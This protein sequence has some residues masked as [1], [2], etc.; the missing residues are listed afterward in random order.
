MAKTKRSKGWWAPGW[1]TARWKS[2]APWNTMPARIPGRAFQNRR[3]RCSRQRHLLW[4]RN[5]K[6]NANPGWNARLGKF[7]DLSKKYHRESI[8]SSGRNQPRP[9]ILFYWCPTQVF[10]NSPLRFLANSEWKPSGISALP[11]IK[12]YSSM[13]FFSL[14]TSQLIVAGIFEHIQSNTGYRISNKSLCQMKPCWF[15]CPWNRSGSSFSNL[16]VHP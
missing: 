16:A 2:S 14:L 13:V 9:A 8:D 11:A 3:F 10:Q 15:A 6:W 1:Q 7:T 12:N 5:S 4:P